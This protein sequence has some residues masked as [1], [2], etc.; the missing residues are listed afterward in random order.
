M[1]D[2][3]KGVRAAVKAFTTQT[4]LAEALGIERSAVS[5]W[6]Q[7]PSKRVLEIETKSGG[8]VSRHDMRPD[9]YPREAA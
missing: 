4:A 9:L 2:L 1:P 6:R 7:V 5:Q 8:K 3:T